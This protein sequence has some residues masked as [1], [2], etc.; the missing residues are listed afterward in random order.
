MTH[1]TYHNP[2]EQKTMSINDTATI[3]NYTTVCPNTS[4]QV[5]KPS[6]YCMYRKD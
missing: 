1:S 5:L 4:R 6:G 2:A 3:S